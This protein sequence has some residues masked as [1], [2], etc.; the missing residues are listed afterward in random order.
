MSVSSVSPTPLLCTWDWE[1][2]GPALPVACDVTRP[3]SARA[4]KSADGA[5]HG[6]H[7]HCTVHRHSSSGLRQREQVWPSQ[8]SR[9]RD[10]GLLIDN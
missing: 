4:R 2:A 1:L 6:G 8:G 3:D 9:R 7:C 5:G 10:L